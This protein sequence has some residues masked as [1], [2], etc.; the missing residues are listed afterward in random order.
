MRQEG[1]LGDEWLV[2]L[3]AGLEPAHGG[4]RPAAQS[5]LQLFEVVIGNVTQIDVELQGVVVL[6]NLLLI[7]KEVLHLVWV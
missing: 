6:Y 3:D 2:L 5:L 7:E 4:V 1:V